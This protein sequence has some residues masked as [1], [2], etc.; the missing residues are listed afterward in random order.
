MP[1]EAIGRDTE[2]GRHDRFAVR[3]LRP[4]DVAATALLQVEMLGEGMFPQLGQAFVRRWHRTFVGH[5][6]V[7][8]HCATNDRGDVLGFLIGALDQRAYVSRVLSRDG[9]PLV[10]PGTLGMARRPALAMR[11]LRSRAVPYA[12]RAM[13]ARRPAEA[14]TPH[15]PVAVVHAVV[16][17]PCARGLGIARELVARFESD[18]AASGTRR[19]QLL[20][21]ES[22]GAAGFYRR[23]G[24]TEDG[25]RVNRDGRRSVQFSKDVRR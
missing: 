12:K 23:L 5:P 10:V 20:T 6:D 22:G 11:F 4:E 1:P 18:V 2:A 8:A 16:T 14:V 9:L 17:A 24:W 15:E 25:V 21:A 13:A 3:R 7:T 19:M